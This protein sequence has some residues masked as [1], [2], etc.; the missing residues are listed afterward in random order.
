MCEYSVVIPCYRSAAWL[1]E[2]VERVVLQM[3]SGYEPFEIVLV[4]DA[5]PDDTW[6][7]IT[8]LAKKY[9]QV[10]GFDMLFNTGQYR[11]T[12][13]GL[14]SAK[15]K[16]IVTM[17]D[18][19]QHAPEDIPVLIEALRSD[20]DL[21]CIMGKYISKR[22]SWLR[23]FGSRLMLWLNARLYGKPAGV[24]PSSFRAMRSEIAKS[25]CLHGTVNP[26]LTP[27]IFRT[28][29]RVGN[30][31]VKHYPRAHGKSGYSMTRLV[32]IVLDNIFGASTFPLRA[33]SL[34]GVGWP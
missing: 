12:L 20:L 18:D 19:L 32:C 3:S 14:D 11:A 27:L 23:N 7:V 24:L 30:A 26:I 34:L 16:V 29:Q 4:N 9:V 28:T 33:V 5:S 10:R 15:G 8:L 6:N 21:D 2:L 22:H 1:E 25:I 13:C 31:T 17:D